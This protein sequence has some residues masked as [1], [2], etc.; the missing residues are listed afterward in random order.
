MWERTQYNQRLQPEWTKLGTEG[1]ASDRWRIDYGYGPA[2]ENNGNVRS[3]T[4]TVPAVGGVAGL[5]A[6]Q[7]Y[8]YDPLNSRP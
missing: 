8:S 6:V 7:T 4:V 5:T 3:Q 1:G 2:G